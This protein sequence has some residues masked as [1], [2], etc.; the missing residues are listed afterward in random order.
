MVPNIPDSPNDVFDLAASVELAQVLASGIEHASQ[1]YGF[2]PSVS[3]CWIG[4][5]KMNIGNYNVPTPPR[6]G[7]G[8]EVIIDGFGI[9]DGQATLNW[10]RAVG[11]VLR[12]LEDIENN[13]RRPT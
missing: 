3:R 1:H 7:F 11:F 2:E 5:I 12:V 9:D 6:P 4:P 10:N 13:Q 8:V